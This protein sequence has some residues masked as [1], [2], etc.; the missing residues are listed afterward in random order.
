LWI[1]HTLSPALPLH[2][3]TDTDMSG[4]YGLTKVQCQRVDF[5]GPSGFSFSDYRAWV[6][7]LE[8]IRE[9]L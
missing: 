7:V 3:A 2:W 5:S 6:R 1:C 8:V 4:S 9:L